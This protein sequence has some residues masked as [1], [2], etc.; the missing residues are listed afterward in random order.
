MYTCVSFPFPVEDINACVDEQGLLFLSASQDQN[1]H[2]WKFQKPSRSANDSGDDTTGD[3]NDVADSAILLHQFKGHARSV[4]ALAVSPNK[5][6][7]HIHTVSSWRENIMCTL[8]CIYI[9]MSCR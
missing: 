9:L 1:V 8:L 5:Q 4:D 3:G 2:L 6:E 7:V